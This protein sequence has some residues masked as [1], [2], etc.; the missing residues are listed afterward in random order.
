MGGEPQYEQFGAYRL[1]HLL[2]KGGMASVYRALRS[3]PMGFSKEVAIKRLH[4]ALTNDEKILK[5]LINEARLGG[6]LKHPNIVEIYEFNK[7]DGKYFLAMEF[8]DGWTIERVVAFARE[9]GEPIPAEVVLEL[10]AQVCDGLHYAHTL[11]ALDGQSVKVVHRDLKPANIMVSRFGIAKIMDFGIAKATTNLFQTTIVDAEHQTTKGTPHYMS[12][13]Q[14][15]GDPNIGFKSDIF[16][17][18]SVIYESVTGEVL[19]SGD[20]L[21]TVLFSVVKADV[22]RQLAEVDHRVPGLS[23]IL[24]KCLA[25]KPEDRWRNAADLGAALQYLRDR[26][27]GQSSVQDY[28]YALRSHLVGHQRQRQEKSTLVSE[29]PEFATLFGQLHTEEPTV[30]RSGLDEAIEAAERSIREGIGS[31][32]VDT[33]APTLQGIPD[34]TGTVPLTRA[35]SSEQA[36]PDLVET[37]MG[38]PAAALKGKK[39]RRS[40]AAEEADAVTR[41]YQADAQP[42]AKDRKRWMIAAFLLVSVAVLAAVA[43]LIGPGE[44]PSTPITPDPG[45]GPTATLNAPTPIPD[46]GS[47]S[48]GET[49][50]AATPSTAVGTVGIPAPT[51][52]VVAAATPGPVEAGATPGPVEA[53]TPVAIAAPT[54]ERTPTVVAVL[55][56]PVPTKPGQL[57]IK[58]SKPWARVLLDGKDIGE[59]TPLIGYRVLAGV[60][61]IELIGSA[62]AGRVSREIKIDAGQRLVLGSYD[63]STSAWSD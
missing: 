62:N 12:P 57:Y 47:K 7:V 56:P 44:N 29:L 60:H 40:R 10:F 16:S 30:D 54:P 45:V 5:S 58:A 63:F 46:L 27:P 36:H 26:M 25:K 35:L 20:N 6:Q 15:A 3:G 43:A 4:D 28:L 49:G 23:S 19:F 17:L 21:A 39:K 31:P 24:L 22:E 32:L 18:G 50:P 14:V 42:P 51:P 53:A 8:V 11:E 61:R 38:V 37:A 9:F 55:D 33:G 48:G 41:V 13:E 1:T 34:E 52:A 59:P 2:G